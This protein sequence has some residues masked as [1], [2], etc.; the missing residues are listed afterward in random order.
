MQKVRD[1]SNRIRPLLV[2]LI[3]YI[4]LL[5]FSTSWLNANPDSAWQIPVASLPL[6][7]GAAIL[8]GILRIVAQMDELE[9]KILLEGT[10]VGFVGTL[11]I[12]ISFGLLQDAGVPP[13]KQIHIALIMV[14]L[15]AV[16]KLR[17]AR[18][19]G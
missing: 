8:W 19:Y 9:R 1:K 15:A 5:V 4:G 11:I 14:I 18:K 7:P 12:V 17:A 3:L 10:A 13:L 2:P 6:F 16:G